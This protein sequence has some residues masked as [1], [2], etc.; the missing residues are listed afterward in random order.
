MTGS[1]T[2]ETCQPALPMSGVRERPTSRLHVRTSELDPKRKSASLK[3][4][5]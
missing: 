3:T 5:A 1:G 4:C 2:F